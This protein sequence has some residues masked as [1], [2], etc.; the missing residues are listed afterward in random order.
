MTAD[1]PAPSMPGSEILRFRPLTDA[2][3][4]ALVDHAGDEEVA[5]WT[6]TIPHPFT[7]TDARDFIAK[8]K[9]ELAIGTGARFAIE[10]HGQSGVVGCIGYM[11]RDDAVEVGYWIGRSV[12]GQGI[13]TEAVRA[14]VAHLFSRGY[15][16]N[17]TAEVM[18]GNLASSRVLEKAGFVRTAET[19]GT[20]GRCDGVPVARYALTRTAWET[21]VRPGSG[22]LVV[23]VAAV[24]LVDADDRV[25]LAQRPEG[26]SMAGLWEFPGG[27]VDSGETPEA[28][29]IR[30][31][32]EELGIDV[33]DNCLAPFTFASHTYDDFH[34]L[35]PLYVCRVWEGMVTPMEGQALK[36]V[37]VDRLV[38]YPMPPADKPLIA[39]LRDLL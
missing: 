21:R 25:L 15:V 31:L 37:R 3:V 1:A 20:F 39:M 14:V 26:K 30:E 2:D 32:K 13:A 4:P 17:I 9:E 24:A 22:A 23:L 11:F 8:A 34:L 27:K 5:R 36:W 7:E 28:A 16:E 33:A 29:L 35:M 18:F 12:W 19:T 38:D 10:R 6:S